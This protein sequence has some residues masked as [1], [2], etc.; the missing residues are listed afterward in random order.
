[1]GSFVVTYTP[2]LLVAIIY[3]QFVG[4]NLF[5]LHPTIVRFIAACWFCCCAFALQIY[6]FE[7]LNL[8][9]FAV[10]VGGVFALLRL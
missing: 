10:I 2:R 9:N 4:P 1:M 5:A 8:S 6:A 7:C 3:E